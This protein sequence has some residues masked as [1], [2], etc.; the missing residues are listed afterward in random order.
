MVEGARQLL[1]EGPCE[2]EVTR[3]PARVLAPGQ[4]DLVGQTPAALVGRHP[5]SVSRATRVCHRVAVTRAWAAAAADFR[6]S[7]AATCSIAS[8]SGTGSPRT[9]SASHHD[10]TTVASIAS[11]GGRVATGTLSIR[12]MSRRY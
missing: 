5:A 12:S 4:G 1:D 2:A 10:A 8:S 6:R 3:A 7:R 11:S 9:R